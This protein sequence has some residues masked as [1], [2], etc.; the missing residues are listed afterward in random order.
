MGADRVL[1]GSD[2]PYEIGDADDAIAVSSLKTATAEIREAV[3]CGNAKR[4]RWPNHGR[5]VTSA[6]RRLF[7]PLLERR[8]ELAAKTFGFFL[9]HAKPEFA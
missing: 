5:P 3:L 8:R 7:E 2:F 6:G 9:H 4:L 1:F